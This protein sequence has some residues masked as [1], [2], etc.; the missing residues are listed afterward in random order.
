ME[1]G[2]IV[3]LS[4]LGVFV[5][6]WAGSFV[7]AGPIGKAIARRIEG[8]RG[9]ADE[10]GDLEVRAAE[11]DALRHRVA[12]LEERL[13]FAERVLAQSREPD[14]LPRTEREG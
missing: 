9:G 13:D 14:R 1:P 12:E 11:A 2:A 8:H 6:V 4:I 5:L 7:L 3:G 10:T